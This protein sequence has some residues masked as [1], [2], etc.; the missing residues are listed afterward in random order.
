MSRERKA[1]K[2]NN[3]SVFGSQYSSPTV[4]RKSFTI[5]DSSEIKIN[6][7]N[8]SLTQNLLLRVYACTPA[9]LHS[10]VVSVM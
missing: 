10:L 6:F 1:I 9:P 4:D 7:C 8:C 2:S 3:R 5:L